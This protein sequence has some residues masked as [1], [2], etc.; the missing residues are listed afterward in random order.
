MPE[1]PARETAM[2]TNARMLGMLACGLALAGAPVRGH[3]AELRGTVLNLAGG[4]LPGARVTAMT[5]DTASA[6]EDRTDGSGTFVFSGLAAGSWIAPGE[7]PPTA[8]VS[9]N[10]SRGGFAVEWFQPRPGPVEIRLIAVSGRRLASWTVE[11]GPAGVRSWRFGD[12]T[13]PSP[14]SGI[15]WIQV[16][17]GSD[18]WSARVVVLP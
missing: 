13:T 18:R 8:R 17:A 1:D 12:E 4:P 6:L 5:P 2:R 16:V 11:E 14:Q 3:G 9:P 15:Y 10:P 7:G